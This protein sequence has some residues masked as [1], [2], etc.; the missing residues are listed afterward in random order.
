MVNPTNAIGAIF[1]ESRVQ[2]KIQKGA[3]R[4]D[5][6]R[7]N[8]AAGVMSRAFHEF[9][10][11]NALSL[12]DAFHVAHHHKQRPSQNVHPA[13]DGQKGKMHE[14]GGYLAPPIR[15]GANAEESG[16]QKTHDGGNV[17]DVTLNL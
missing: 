4:S 7:G 14:N 15:D 6:Q 1:H 2:M 8:P 5:K 9:L 13:K 17:G 10:R 16:R 11:P 12:D 3:D